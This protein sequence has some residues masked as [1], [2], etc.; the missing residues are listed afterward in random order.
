MQH[1]RCLLLA[2]AV[3]VGSVLAA[4][5]PEPA[6]AD[7]LVVA[8]ARGGGLKPGQTIDAA[9][10]IKLGSGERV[11]LIAS[12]GAII[13]LTGPFEGVPDISGR[14]L[15]SV[16]ESLV[17]L[18]SQSTQSSTTLGTVRAPNGT[19]PPE[20]WLI[21]VG[22]SGHRCVQQD[23]S[24]V[25]WRPPATTDQTMQLSPSDRAW[26]GQAKWPAGA[27]QLRMPSSFQA[28]D[29]Q[30]YIVAIDSGAS[31]VTLH[32]IPLAMDN[33]MMRA[34]WMLDQGCMGQAQLLISRL[35]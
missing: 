24:V 18:G 23:A 20:P 33:D 29:G 9:Q 34:A 28:Q 1:C 16:A 27:D 32:V 15:A 26:Q 13:K 2:A 31:T 12:N 3:L 14:R 11:T 17:R 19:L 21:D 35:K 6:R 5:V 10:P 30:A 4:L 8:E 22:S 7:S 25:F